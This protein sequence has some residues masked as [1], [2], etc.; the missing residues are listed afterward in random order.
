MQKTL[1]A[2]ITKA[3][4]M[5]IIYMKWFLNKEHVTHGNETTNWQSIRQA[6]I[7]QS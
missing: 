3:I 4:E 6:E 5:K 2:Q 1:W 7:K